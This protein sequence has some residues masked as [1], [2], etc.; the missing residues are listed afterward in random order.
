MK[1]ECLSTNDMLQALTNVSPC[2]DSMQFSTGAQKDRNSVQ[3]AQVHQKVSHG[4]DTL[5]VFIL[6]N[7]VF[8]DVFPVSTQGCV[9]SLTHFIVIPVPHPWKPQT[10]IGATL[11]V[12]V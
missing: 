1:G 10:V 7:N 9:H 2:S 12:A 6:I 4:Q 3:K 8:R 11:G 5:C